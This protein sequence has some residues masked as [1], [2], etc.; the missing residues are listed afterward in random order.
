MAV[1]TK[2]NF[3][4]RRPVL[5]S[6]ISIVITLVGALAMK[7]LPIAQYPDLVPPTVNV[8]AAYPGASAETIAS[9]V[10]APLEVSINGVENMLYMTSTA[11]SGSGSGS[12]NVYFALG[13][14]PDMALVNVNN[15]V[16]LAQTTLPEDVRRQGVSVVKRSPAMLQ[17]FAFF[18]PDGRYDQIYIHNW[19]QINVVDELK[20]VEG[21]GDCSVFGSMDYAMRVWL[22]PDKLAKYGVSVN[23]VKA[24]IQEQNSQYAPGRLGDMPTSADTQLAWQIDTQGRLVTPEEF[25]EIIIRSGPDSAMLRLRD[26]AHIEMGGK[27]YSVSSTYNGMVARMGAVYLLPGANAIATGDR[28]K[29]KL[30]EIGQR[31]PDGMEYKIVVDT[32]DFVL[33]S[34]HEVLSTLVEAMILVIIVVYVFLQNWRATLI[35]CIAV[36]VSIIGTFAGLY[37]FGYTIN[38]LTLF[39]MVLAIG[40]VVDDAIVVLENVERIMSTEHLPPKEATA[41]AMNEVTAPVVAIVLVLCAVFIPVSFMGGLAGQMYKQ[42][43]I[44]ISV[45]V[46]LSG[47]VALTLTPALCAL[48]LKP[49]DHDYKPLRGF[50]WFNYAFGRVTRRYVN[51]VR[52]IKKSTVRALVLCAIMV[53]FTAWLFRVVPGGLVPN[54]DQGYML[55]MYILDDGASQPR[56]AKVGEVITGFLTKQPAVEAI[57]TINGLDITSISVK[58]NYGTFFAKLKPWEERTAPGMSADDVTNKVM[59]VTMMQPEAV[60]LGFTPPPISGM[61]TTGGFEGYVQMRGTGSLKDM[62]AM[63]NKLVAEASAK[64]PDGTPKY[65]AI[66]MVRNLFST[67]SP[68]LYANLDRDRC[69]DMGISIA[70]VFTAMGG[71][72]G[73]AYVNDFNYLGRTFQVRLQSEHNYRDL[74]EDLNDVYVPNNKGEMVPLTAVMTLERRTAPQVVERYNVFPAA[75]VM[76]SPA[77]GYSSGQAIAAMEEAAAAVLDTDYQL[78]WVG[79]ALQEKLAS[80]DT[81]TIF[82]LALV[83]VF[84]ILAAQYESWSLPL[85][86]LTAVPF[87]VFGALLATWARG[88]SNDV[89]FQVALVT[90]IGLAAKNAILIVEFAV[91]AWRAGRSLDAAALHASK[92]RFR[93]IIMTSLAFILGCVPL[94]ISSGAGANSRHSIGTAVI[95]GML[96]ATC[97][98]TLF[99][100][101]FFKLIMQISLKIQ[102]KTDPHEGRNSVGDEQEEI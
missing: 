59:A 5:S 7:A 10:L 98:A 72:F 83:M 75:H 63:A 27:D 95:G 35:P 89:Y 51:I 32:N 12:I 9:T 69:K 92:L 37:A 52:F 66:G 39:A 94:A 46:V 20:R 80:A 90:L 84:L 11:G 82:V 28:V 17:A 30:A 8:S 21:V 4:L 29:A 65:P 101:F 54:E 6:V 70:D 85:A 13:S 55:G 91:E 38:T 68:Q 1:S 33:E 41:K 45:S 40:I 19:M 34:I 24:A 23:Q 57:T 56:T 36:P 99:I 53:A 26:V 61:S 64:K 67:G 14:N 102:G 50:V 2:P 81:T 42:F 93:P 88:L 79:S 15:K 77:P 97:I 49:H 22:Q 96:V 76:G 16:N 100:P 25:G 78:G 71:T 31:L 58:S 3:F 60:V 47:V 18:S 44:T 43:A 87:G 74:P 86:V 48:L 73:G 62:E